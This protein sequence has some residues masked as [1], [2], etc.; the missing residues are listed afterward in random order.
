MTY[1]SWKHFTPIPESKGRAFQGQVHGMPVA[2]AVGGTFVGNTSYGGDYESV[3]SSF[4]MSYLVIQVSLKKPDWSGLV[5]D[6]DLQKPDLWTANT[7]WTFPSR[8]QK[9]LAGI[10]KLSKYTIL[11]FEVR[12]DKLITTK[13][14]APDS[15]AEIHL[16]V[17]LV[18]EVALA[19]DMSQRE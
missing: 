8:I 14:F 9:A 3:G 2:L 12:G 6:R 15:P 13:I 4:H 5:L 7:P 17:D 11:R 19:L 10:S 16:L 1:A 18:L